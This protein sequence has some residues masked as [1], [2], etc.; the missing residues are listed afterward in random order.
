MIKVGVIGALLIGMLGYLQRSPLPLPEQDL[1]VLGKALFFDPI[2]SRDASLSCAS[3]HQPALAFTDGREVSIGVEGRKG[4]RNSM[5]LVNLAT[6]QTGFFWDGRVS[7]LE[8]Q[9]LHPITNPNEMG[10]DLEQVVGRLALRKEYQW[11]FDESSIEDHEGHFQYKGDAPNGVHST[12]LDTPVERLGQALAAYLRSITLSDSKFDR[13]LSGEENFTLS[14][15]RGWAIFFDATDYLPHG[16]CSH[17]HTDPL[18]TNHKFFNNGISVVTDSKPV[19]DPGQGGIT[20]IPQQMGRFRTP[21][22]RNIAVTA[23]Y[24]HDGRFQTLEEV[25]DHYNSGGRQGFNV[26]PNVRPLHL[27]KEDMK[28]VIAFLHTLTDRSLVDRKEGL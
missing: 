26:N 23:P 10:A 20:G 13:V 16:E 14:E 1:E 5:T 19:E 18:F 25:I 9:V 8:E 7:K 17:C 6:I 3:C 22:L 21:T 15:E 4:I 28:D 2:L 12:D 11:L 24:M 27:S